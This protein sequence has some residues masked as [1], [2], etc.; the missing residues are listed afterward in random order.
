[1]TRAEIIA[2]QRA[3]NHSGLAYQVLGEP[4][5]EDGIYGPLTQAA[6]QAH[7]DAVDQSAVPNVTPAAAK[8][9]WASRAV[10]G[11]LATV[12]AGLANRFGWE[13]SD[14]SI[15]PILLH[16]V[17]LGGLA[18]AAWGTVRRSA[19]IDPTLAARVGTHDVRLPV[20]PQR[21]VD[22]D[23]RGVFRDS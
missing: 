21:P 6:H 5:D 7:L 18:L 16:A 1:M 10:L 8:P 9:W 22:D 2:L 14:D 17:E 23:P 11:L 3:L 12:L 13:I 15:L 4:L 20:R 19:P